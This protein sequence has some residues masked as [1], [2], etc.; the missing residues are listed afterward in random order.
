MM[1]NTSSLEEEETEMSD[2]STR[3]DMYVCSMTE[4]L[5]RPSID[6]R[7]CCCRVN[8]T[9]NFNED[10]SYSCSTYWRV[11]PDKRILQY[12]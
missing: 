10:T 12:P 2:C 1:Y 11:I 5:A 9:P 8:Y 7:A 4:F 3:E 6:L